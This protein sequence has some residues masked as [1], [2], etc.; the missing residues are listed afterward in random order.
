MPAVPADGLDGFAE[1]FDAAA[2]DEGRVG[3][4]MDAMLAREDCDSDTLRRALTAR[5]IADEGL[6]DAWAE[7]EGRLVDEEAWGDLDWDDLG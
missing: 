4:V 2:T 5:G 7:A 1:A 3:A 6:D